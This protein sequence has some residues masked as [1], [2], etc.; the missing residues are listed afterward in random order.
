MAGAPAF[1]GE[2]RM[3]Q[4]NRREAVLFIKIEPYQRLCPFLV[5]RRQ[6]GEREHVWTLDDP[7]DAFDFER[8]SHSHAAHQPTAAGPQIGLRIR[9]FEAALFTPPLPPPR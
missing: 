2:A 3:G 4:A 9:G 7:I 1:A 5:P 6:P 8:S